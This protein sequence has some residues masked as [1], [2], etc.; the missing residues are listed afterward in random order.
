MPVA[1]DVSRKTGAIYVAEAGDNAELI[2]RIRI[3]SPEGKLQN[4]EIGIGGDFNGKWYPLS[5]AFSSGGGDIALDPQGGLWV[6][7]NGHR[8]DYCPLLT[9]LAPAPQFTPDLTLHGVNGT[10][11][12]VDPKLDVYVGGSYKIS[13][14]DTLVW[15]SGLIDPG[16]AGLFPTTLG[17][18]MMSPVWSD[19]N[20]AVIASVHYNNFYTVNAKN[21]AALGKTLPA[22][23]TAIIGTSVVDRDLFYAGAGRTIQRTTLD[24]EAPQPFVTLPEGV[25]PCGAI[26]VSPDKQQVYVTYVADAGK[27]TQYVALACYRKDGTPVWAGKGSV[28]ALYKGVLFTNNPDGPGVAALAA[29]TGQRIALFGDKAENGQPPVAAASLAIGSKDGVDY[30]FVMSNARIMVYRVNAG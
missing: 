9:H 1:L 11:L 8:M 4:Q 26:A 7:G 28:M 16:P 3:Y 27:P 17:G 24:L 6:N 30:L 2:N 25:T 29:A 14:D 18:W 15:T 5:F 21:G 22:G 12:A 10:G 19:G 13:W 23:T 20:T